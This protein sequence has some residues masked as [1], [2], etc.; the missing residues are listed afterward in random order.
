MK[1][2]KLKITNSFDCFEEQRIF[3]DV[4]RFSHNRFKDGMTEKSI[5]ETCRSLFNLNSWL[6]LCAVKEGKAIFDK[7]KENKIVFGG[8]HN[9][10]KYLKKLITKEEY[11]KNRMSPITIQGEK[12]FHGNRLF[13]FDLLNSKL[14]FKLNKDIHKN[15]VIPKLRNNIK[16]EFVEL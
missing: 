15:I 12:Q 10:N 14:V 1:T 11:K 6:I 3:N 8:K 5:Y 13:D 16:R 9:F 7:F 4:M 2:I